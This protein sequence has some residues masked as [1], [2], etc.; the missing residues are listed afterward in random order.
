MDTVNSMV[1]RVIFPPLFVGQSRTLML[2]WLHENY[3]YSP[4][5]SRTLIM[6]VFSLFCNGDLMW[7][8]YLIVDAKALCTADMRSQLENIEGGSSVRRVR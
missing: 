3:M 8:M 6:R 2:A 4:K 5:K 7:R 1:V